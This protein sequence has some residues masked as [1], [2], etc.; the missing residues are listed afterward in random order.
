[1]LKDSIL[2]EIRRMTR[3]PVYLVMMIVVPIGCAL[4]FISLMHE[5]L[6]LKVPTAIVDLD[7]SSMSRQIT[8]SLSAMELV[9]IADKEESYSKALAAVR[10]GDIFGLSL[11]HI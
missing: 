4:F 11:I 10:R 8:R 7:H 9:E 5:G 3:Y 1:M 2:R 6:P